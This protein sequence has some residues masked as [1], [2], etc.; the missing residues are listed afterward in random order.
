MIACLHTIH[1][2]IFGTAVAFSLVACSPDGDSASRSTPSAALDST[3]PTTAALLGAQQKELAEARVH[4]ATAKPTTYEVTLS[5]SAGMMTEKVCRWRVSDTDVNLL[6]GSDMQYCE[7]AKIRT[8]EDMFDWIE[9]ALTRVGDFLEVDY[10]S[11]GVPSA[12]SVVIPDAS[13]LDSRWAM[14]VDLA[15]V[16][17]GSAELR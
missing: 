15:G 1:R 3:I 14:T 11:R 8:P 13:D 4:W 12:G 5:Q 6:D 2:A 9:R 16:E 10:D 17:A 7:T